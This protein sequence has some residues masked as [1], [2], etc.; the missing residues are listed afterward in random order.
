MPFN[1][2][3]D[4][5][6]VPVNTRSGVN[7][8]ARKRG[9][10]NVDYETNEIDEA[11]QG[12]QSVSG[13]T[14]EYYRF[15]RTL[16][17]MDSLYDESTGGGRVY[18]GPVPLAALHVQHVQGAREDLEGGSYY[19][20]SIHVTL[21]FETYSQTGMVRADVDHQKYMRDRLV[22]DGKVFK[23]NKVDVLGQVQRRDIIITIDGE[24]VRSDELVDDPQFKAYSQ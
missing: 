1:D 7:R 16:S 20:D 21:M 3:A 6:Y 2:Y 14:V 15:E 4:R 18:T 19:N 24:Q 11:L 5:P 13:D 10:F 9:R 17:T 22:Y 23:V 12:Q 8:L